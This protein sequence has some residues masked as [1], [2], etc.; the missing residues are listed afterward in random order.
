MKNE[1]ITYKEVIEQI[2]KKSLAEKINHLRSEFLMYVDTKTISYFKTRLGLKKEDGH[3]YITVNLTK[4]QRE[5]A[6]EALKWF[7]RDIE[8]CLKHL[9]D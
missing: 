1:L 9:E 4:R 2:E 7:K 3:N 6:I 8:E 5:D